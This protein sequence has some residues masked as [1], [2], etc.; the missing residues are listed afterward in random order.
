MGTLKV[1][2][3]QG[4]SGSG[5]TAIQATNTNDTA[6]SGYFGELKSQSR[7]RAAWTNLTS[8]ATVNVTAN[9]NNL[10]P[11]N[12]FVSGSVAIR[13]E[14][15]T[16]ITEIDIAISA[17]SG[18]VPGVGAFAVPAGGEFVV[19]KKFNALVLGAGDTMIEIPPIPISLAVTTPTYLVANVTFGVASCAA[20]GSFWAWRPR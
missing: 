9:P 10:D 12:W 14:A 20:Y 8:A 6:A 18:T 2:T 5:G 16:T 3:I 13:T 19:V 4:P 15:T 1:S 7:L 11:G 17:V